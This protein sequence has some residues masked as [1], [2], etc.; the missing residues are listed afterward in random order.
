M[1]WFVGLILAAL[2]TRSSAQEPAP[3]PAPRAPGGPAPSQTTRP[4]LPR[5]LQV[6]R[7]GAIP[8]TRAASSRTLSSTQIR[9]VLSNPAG[10]AG[11]GDGWVSNPRDTT[12]S[13]PAYAL[14][15]ALARRDANASRPNRAGFEMP[16][17]TTMAS[18]GAARAG[19]AA[20]AATYRRTQ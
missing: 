7:R 17:R 20:A 11:Y 10:L 18:S 5:P 16:R 3:G 19:A 1:L 15:Y 13:D 4:A 8:Q 2:S 6:P 14:G 9:A 12:I